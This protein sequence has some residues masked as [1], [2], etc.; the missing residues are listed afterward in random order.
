MLVTVPER[1]KTLLKN[2]ILQMKAFA[3]YWSPDITFANTQEAGWL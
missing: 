1:K 3:F 2:Q